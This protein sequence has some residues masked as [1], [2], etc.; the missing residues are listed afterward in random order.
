MKQVDLN[1]VKEN[2]EYLAIG[3]ELLTSAYPETNSLFLA[4]KLDNLGLRLRYK[5]VVSDSLEDIVRAVKVALNRSRLIFISGGLGPTE[6]DRTREAVAQAVKK[7]LIFYP[8]IIKKIEDRFAWRGAKMTP[9][10]RQQAYI[11][12]GAEILDNPNGTAPGMWLETSKHLLVLLP[13]PPAEFNPMV[14][15]LMADRLEL[16]RNKYVLKAVIKTTGAGESWVEDRIKSVYRLLPEDLEL[17]T[18][19]SP[20]EVQIRLTLRVK[21]TNR[22]NERI[23]DKVKNKIINLL[24]DKVFSTDGENLEEVIGHK[25]A[26][27]GQTV[28][29]AESCTGGLL[30]DRITAVPGSSNYFLASLVTYSNRAKTRFLGVP[31]RLIRE[32]GA[33]SREVAESMAAGARKKTGATLALATTGIAGPGGGSARKPVGLVY[34][35]LAS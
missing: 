9:S 10:N 8:E 31:T 13:G 32:K 17:T 1:Q 5:S 7:P 27:L 12:Q 19:A 25:L 20:G 26:A 34:I 11:I 30:A 24:G 3:S 28:A 29:C 6:D 2:I 21:E 33:V 18:L 14:E 4:E 22:E 15:K 35:G 23:F 16:Y